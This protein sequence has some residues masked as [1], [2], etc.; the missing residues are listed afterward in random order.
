MRDITANKLVEQIINLLR[1]Y[2]ELSSADIAKMLGV[3]R[4]S[5]TAVLAKMRREGLVEYLGYCFGGRRC[6]TKWRLRMN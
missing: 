3:K 6:D 5:V 1:E 2:G 4:R